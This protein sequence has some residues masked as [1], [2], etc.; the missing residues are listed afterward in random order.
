MLTSKTNSLTYW[1]KI[2]SPTDES[3]HLLRLFSIMNFS[4]VFLQSFSFE[5]KAERHDLDS[6]GKRIE[7][8]F[9][10]ARPRSTCLVSRIL[11]RANHFSSVDS[12]A[13]HCPGNQELDQ[14][15][16][17]GST[18]IIRDS[19]Q[20][21]A[22]ISQEWQQ[23]GNPFRDV[24]KLVRSDTYEDSGS[25]EKRVRCVVNQHARTRTDFT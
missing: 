23:D 20:D 2:V 25:S 11:L 24:R 16:V 1:L 15:F 8:G 4:T 12:D 5:Q 22:T 7:E 18:G 6:S 13:S 9:A 3:K 14:T 10:K 21:P 17:S 19:N